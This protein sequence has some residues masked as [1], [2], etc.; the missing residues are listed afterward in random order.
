MNGHDLHTRRFPEDIQ[1]DLSKET[2]T[3]HT[4]A[5]SHS[6]LRGC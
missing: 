3:H 5:R 4:H 2:E 1:K 6:F